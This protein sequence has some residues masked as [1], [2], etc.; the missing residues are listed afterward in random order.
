MA[1]DTRIIHVD[2]KDLWRQGEP[3]SVR[4]LADRKDREQ[5]SGAK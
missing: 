3:K 1:K 2:K 5:S 4:D